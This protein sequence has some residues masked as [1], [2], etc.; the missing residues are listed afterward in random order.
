MHW[1]D[2]IPTRAEMLRVLKPGGWLGL[3]HNAGKD[4]ERGLAMNALRSEE[5]GVVP[6]AFRQ[7]VTPW[8]SYFDGAPV[9]RVAFPF[10]YVQDWQDFIGALL[11]TSY[12]PDIDHP[13]YPRMEQAA[14]QI[15]ERFSRDGLLAV[16]GE[17]ELMMGQP[18]QNPPNPP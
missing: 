10:T 5:Y 7:P 6:P 11:S 2:F 1:F 8:E 12:F 4:E 13:L 18:N 14:R 9:Q 15:F 3:F 16:H 17:T